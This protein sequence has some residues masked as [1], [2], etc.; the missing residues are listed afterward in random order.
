MNR[1]K[2]LPARTT[3]LPLIGRARRSGLGAPAGLAGLGAGVLLE[4]LARARVLDDL[5]RLVLP[6][7]LV[8][9]GRLVVFR[10]A[11]L[12]AL[13]A[14]GHVAHDRG[15]LAAAAE[16]QQRHGEEDEPM[17]DAQA[18]HFIPL[19]LRPAPQDHAF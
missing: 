2:L 3:R 4:G 6:R 13:Y 12:E 10:H 8:L 7:G 18:T 11:L 16:Q 14:L 1:E 19:L 17:P 15:N 9:L 5:R